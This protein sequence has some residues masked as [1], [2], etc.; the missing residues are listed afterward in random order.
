MK[1][2]KLFALSVTTCMS[3]LLQGCNMPSA[4]ASGGNDSV[5]HKTFSEIRESYEREIEAIKS[6]GY[7]NLNFDKAVFAPPPEVDSIS[8]LKLVKL[9]G[10]TTDEIYDFFCKS[11]DTLT[12]NKYTDEEKG[13]EIRFLDGER[14]ESK[15]PPYDFPNID[16]YK[17]GK[18]TDDPW[19]VLDD[20][21]YFIWLGSGVLLKFNNGDLLDYEGTPRAD[22]DLEGDYTMLSHRHVLY[23][24]DLASTEAYRLIDGEIS[25]ADAAKF[26][27]NY[28][29]NLA[30]TPYTDANLVKPVICAVNVFDIGSGCYGYDFVITYEYDGVWFDRYESKNGG[31]GFTGVDT[32]YDKR[33]Y[34][35]W[36]GCIDMIRTNKIHCFADVSMGYDVVDGEPITEIITVESAA[37][38]VN[39]FFSGH[40]K[41]SV[42]EVSM[43]RLHT[44]EYGAAEQEAY[45]CWKFKMYANGE[46]YHTFVDVITGEVHLYI[47]AV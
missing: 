35:S 36:M 16:E 26:A 27:Q 47:Q 28:L 1:R 25:I 2:T 44:S 7:D 6:K 31:R 12:G 11:V 33:T 46:I 29:D 32:D 5:E 34:G 10:K 4:T 23:T 3:L 17:S 38:T 8:E 40:M 18:E 9:S 45:P 13:H 20:K 21:N 39:N 41:F 43:V 19:L 15:S 24:E 37:D 14:D 22:A 30:F 42:T